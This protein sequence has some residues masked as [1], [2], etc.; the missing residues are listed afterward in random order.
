MDWHHGNTRFGSAKQV[1]HRVLVRTIFGRP[2]ND[3]DAVIA[4]FAAAVLQKA[5]W[6][7]KRRIAWCMLIGMFR[8]AAVHRPFWGL[9]HQELT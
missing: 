1:F 9:M 2:P 6:V 7:R 5:L 3:Q 8:I 4:D